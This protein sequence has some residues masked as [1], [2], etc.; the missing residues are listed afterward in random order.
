MAR[1][2]TF[3][4]QPFVW[5][6]FD[7]VRRKKKISNKSSLFSEMV[8]FYCERHPELCGY[9]DDPQMRERTMRIFTPPPTA[10]L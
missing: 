6:K 5:E 8:V 2:S 7:A 3:T 9:S 10:V 1:Q 4:A